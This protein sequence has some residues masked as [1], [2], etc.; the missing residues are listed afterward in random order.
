MG[1]APGCVTTAGASTFPDNPIIRY[2]LAIC[3]LF[4]SHLRDICIGYEQD[5]SS[6]SKMSRK[7]HPT[8]YNGG[9]EDRQERTKAPHRKVYVAG[10]AF[11]HKEDRQGARC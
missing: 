10:P 11:D 1:R 4:V 3:Y 8:I 5:V 7:G 9:C 2:L 6:S